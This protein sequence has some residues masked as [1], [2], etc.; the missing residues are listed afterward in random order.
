[1]LHP[2]YESL[3]E[4]PRV[5][6]FLVSGDTFAVL[7]ESLRDS[8]NPSF[9]T[10]LMELIDKYW[11]LENKEDR[12]RSNGDQHSLIAELLDTDP[13]CIEWADGDGTS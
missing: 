7:R 10:R 1:M 2:Y 12:F 9:Q 3:A 6:Q 8:I 11:M 13:S 5:K 4:L